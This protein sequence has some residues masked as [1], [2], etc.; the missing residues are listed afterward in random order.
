[1]AAK[2]KCFEEDLAHDVESAK[3][4]DRG[5]HVDRDHDV[6]VVLPHLLKSLEQAR[7]LTG[8]CRLILKSVTNICD[9]F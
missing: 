3:P 5:H 7:L 8:V 6:P 9:S 2:S 4:A 1:M